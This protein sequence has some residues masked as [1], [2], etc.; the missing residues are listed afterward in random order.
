LDSREILGV[1]NSGN[2]HVN[3]VGNNVYYKNMGNGKYSVF[4]E[5]PDGVVVGATDNMTRR[6]VDA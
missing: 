5:T 2:R 6:E 4:P 3:D 1:K